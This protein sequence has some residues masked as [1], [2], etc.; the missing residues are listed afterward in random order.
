MPGEFEEETDMQPGLDEPQLKPEE[1]LLPTRGSTDGTDGL[2]SQERMRRGL[3]RPRLGRPWN[4][5]RYI[6]QVRA[7]LAFLLAINIPLS[8]LL[9]G[10]AILS[11]RAS[12]EEMQPFLNGVVGP[13]VALAS[14]AVGYYLGYMG[15]RSSREAREDR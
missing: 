4:K 10:S 5:A 1:P 15:H 14:G 11:R 13:I 9:Y 7:R 2:A 3:Y 8:I 6:E 12:M